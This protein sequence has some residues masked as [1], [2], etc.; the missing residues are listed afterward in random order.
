MMVITSVMSQ[1]RMAPDWLAG[2]TARQRAK[3]AI[4]RLSAPTCA[5]ISFGLLSC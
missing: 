5:P 2:S 3:A 1:A 4:G